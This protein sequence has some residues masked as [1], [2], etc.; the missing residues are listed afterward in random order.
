MKAFFQPQPGISPK[1]EDMFTP[2]G[3]KADEGYLAIAIAMVIV[4]PKSG[5]TIDHS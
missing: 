4:S 5:D 2:K 3:S 1:F